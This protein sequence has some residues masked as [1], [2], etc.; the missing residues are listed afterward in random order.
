[1]SMKGKWEWISVCGF[2]KHF[3]YL[4]LP[5]EPNPGLAIINIL[6]FVCYLFLIIIYLLLKQETMCMNKENDSLNSEVELTHV[7]K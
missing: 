4:K 5:R 2:L 3:P 6:M 7:S 1:M